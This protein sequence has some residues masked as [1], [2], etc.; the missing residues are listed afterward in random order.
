MSPIVA[1]RM[2]T[3]LGLQNGSQKGNPATAGVTGSIAGGGSDNP[4]RS[5][6]GTDQAAELEQINTWPRKR[7]HR[8]QNT[9]TG[10][11][12]ARFEPAYSS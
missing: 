7:F 2:A 9:G 3:M 11:P 8:P 4:D 1:C 12:A 5:T 6:Q 10:K